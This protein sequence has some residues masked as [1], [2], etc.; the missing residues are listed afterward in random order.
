TCRRFPL[1]SGSLLPPL[2][3]PCSLP[4]RLF[5]QHCGFRRGQSCTESPIKI[6]ELIRA[7]ASSLQVCNRLL[8]DCLALSGCLLHTPILTPNY[9]ERRDYIGRISSSVTSNP[10]KR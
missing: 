2:P 8:R 6:L 4:A 9:P 1:Q 7:F 5:A 3:C 10:I